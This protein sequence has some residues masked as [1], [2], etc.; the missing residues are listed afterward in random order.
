V[1]AFLSTPAGALTAA[2]V[3]TAL[4]AWESVFP[5]WAPY[6]VLYAIAAIALPLWIPAQWIPAQW[7]PPTSA[8]AV[9]ARHGG[10]AAALIALYV[11]FDLGVMGG[12]LG[13]LLVR[14][15][16]DTPFYS[17]PQAIDAVLAL[18]S[19]RLGLSSEASLGLFAAFVLLWAPVGEEL[20]YRRY[21]YGALRQRWG[22]WGAAGLSSALFGLR[23]VTHL[24]YTWPEV[25][26][27]AAA[28]YAL[29]TAVFGVGL[30]LLYERSRSLWLLVAVHA[31]TNA[32]LIALGG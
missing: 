11:A 32:V 9:L 21:L 14:A 31:L 10:P 5:P 22:V 16:L 2:V 26:W 7:S 4:V 27:A 8:R 23:H 17:L 13:G 3:L 20:F 24:L 25:A 1:Q 28:Q 12:L 15:G 6:F 30:C 29:S 18:A 19:T